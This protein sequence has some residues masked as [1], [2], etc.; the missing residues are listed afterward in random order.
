MGI[1]NQ[2]PK[3]RN[4]MLFWRSQPDARS[5]VY[6]TDLFNKVYV[7][8]TIISTAV[9]LKMAFYHVMNQ[10]SNAQAVCVK[11]YFSL[12]KRILKPHL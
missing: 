1:E 12:I 9:S 10:I 6:S 2:D 4:H 5:P 3:I 8:Y 11:Y 7:L